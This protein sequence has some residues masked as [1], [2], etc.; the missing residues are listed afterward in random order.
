MSDLSVTAQYTSAAW[1]WAEFPNADL[2]VTD[3]AKRVFDTV[4]GALA[5]ARPFTRAPS[6]PHSLAARHRVIDELVLA[7]GAKHVIELA[8]GLSRRGVTMTEDPTMQY[9]EIDLPHVV[10]AKRRIL[11]RTERGRAALARRGF[12]IQ[13]GDV[14]TIDLGAVFP[15]VRERV[16]VVAEG[17]LMYLDESAQKSLFS[18]VSRRLAANGGCF[19]FDLV[20]QSEQAKPG[21]VGRALGGAMKLFTKG[22]AF[23]RDER[24]RADVQRDLESAGFAVTVV[25]PSHGRDP[26]LPPIQQL[27]FSC[28]AKSAATRDFLP[29]HTGAAAP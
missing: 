15:D 4:N 10:S 17:L 29:S 14:A 24:G 12:T 18:A 5:I 21:L 13:E 11:E 25:D 9:V 6:L 26:G 20:P 22:G 23:V 27:V 8:A 1:A 3:D 16:F 19:A 28:R 7:S 2:L